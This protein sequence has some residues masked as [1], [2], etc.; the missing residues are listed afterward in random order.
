MIYLVT[1]DETNTCKIGFS[2][3]PEKRLAQLQTGNPFPLQIKAI[4]EGDIALEKELHKKFSHLS[5]SGEWFVYNAEIKDYFQI[6]EFYLVYSSLIGL[7]GE[8]TNP[9]VKVLSYILL[10]FKIH[11]QF[12]IGATTRKLI[13]TKMD[14]SMSA[15]AN[16]LTELKAKNIVYS[17]MRSIYQI[18]PRY[19][20]QGSTSERSKQLK[21][22]IE[23]GCKD[24]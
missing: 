6:E 11:T 22:I 2:S 4:I 24:C 23:L 19:A 1:C 10:N 13:S 17:P 16:A 8:L 20:F 15:V 18:N 3:N 21:A 5:Q 12:E 14:I 9:S 7:L